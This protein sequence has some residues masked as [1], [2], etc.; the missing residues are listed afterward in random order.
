MV[1]KCVCT[2]LYDVYPLPLAPL[3]L[4]LS[5]PLFLSIS[6]S[7]PPVLPLLVWILLLSN[8]PISLYFSLVHYVQRNHIGTILELRMYMHVQKLMSCVEEPK[9]WCDQALAP[10][11]AYIH[12]I[13]HNTVKIIT[14]RFMIK[15]T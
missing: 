9:W 2:H 5:L 6:S 7:D 8:I 4:S 3:S 10:V 12:G 11:L 13:F 1:M 14:C 15:Y